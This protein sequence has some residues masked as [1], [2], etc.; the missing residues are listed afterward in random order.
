M[1]RIIIADDE[2][3]SRQAL[4]KVFQT[5]FPEAQIV[6]EAETGH[7]A[8]ELYLECRPDLVLMDVKMPGMDGLDAA[9]A[10]LAS[11]KQANIIIL[12]AHDQFSYIQEALDIGVKGYLLKPTMQEEN[13]DKIRYWLQRI[14]E[15]DA[16]QSRQAKLEYQIDIASSAI[17]KQLIQSLINRSANEA[18]V[19]SWL[20]FL[21][22]M[23]VP[24]SMWVI[25]PIWDDLEPGI[26]NALTREHV[27]DQI[28][29]VI[30]RY[31]QETTKCLTAHVSGQ[32]LAVLVS[33]VNV[34]AGNENIYFSNI[35]RLM[36]RRVTLVTQNQIC[37]GISPTFSELHEISDAWKQAL[38][39]VRQQGDLPGVLC[40]REDPDSNTRMEKY[41]SQLES[42][43]FQ[44]IRT[45]T[46]DEVLEKFNDLIEGIF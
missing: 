12:T 15:Q 23:P 33:H 20:A 17:E 1:Y 22:F 4:H 43:L 19:S 16:I 26:R 14:A 21:D 29:A 40:W 8:V 45:G 13:I 42:A 32:Y 46:N 39:A 27:L 30:R 34:P 10:I 24:G 37:I 2:F 3:L 41:P 38:R 6:G 9:R 28:Q 5:H 18:D 35:A 25:K 36:I 11:D 31:F 7:K 44:C